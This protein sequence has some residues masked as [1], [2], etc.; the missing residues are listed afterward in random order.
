[1]AKPKIGLYWCSGCGGCEESVVDLAEGLLDVA[2]AVDIVFWPVAMDFKYSDVEALPDGSL[3]AV[4]ING[5]IRL[6]EQ[7]QIAR[8]LRR[9]AQIVIAHG[10]CAYLGGIVG[11]GNFST[12]EDLLRQAYEK[13]P[14]LAR[15]GVPQE[16][17][18]ID[19]HEVELP[20]VME[21]VR[22][23]DQVIDVDYYLPGC[24]PTPEL[25]LAA[26]T[27]LLE[28]KL[29]PR[30]AVL[31]DDRALCDSCSRRDSKPEDLGL[32]GFHRLYEVEIEPDRCFLAQGLI[33]MGPVTRGGCRERCLKGNLPCSG[34][35][36]PLEGVREQGAK[37]VSTLAGTV[38]L[39]EPGE[40][41]AWVRSIP[42]PAGQ[43]YRYSLATSALL[44]G[45][46]RREAR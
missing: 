2:Q 37:F 17:T 18:R 27:A 32:K 13:A 3:A 19:G 10:T 21:C 26:V 9:K 38:E 29:P 36:G 39:S 8:L 16:R 14:S 25:L 33:C 1:M 44:R 30:G 31:A 5:A 20:R 7:E 28:G 40:V 43:L 42:D 22:P 41:E 12:R 4:L 34:C 15:P 35:F 24:P 11:L 23:L 6:T 46:S 45:T